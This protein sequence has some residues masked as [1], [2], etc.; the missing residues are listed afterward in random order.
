MTF[1]RLEDHNSLP[2][3]DPESGLGPPASPAR[4]S[5]RVKVGIVSTEGTASC[6][7]G[8]EE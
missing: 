3:S 6:G 7:G 8:N 4:R 1:F 5:K 2:D